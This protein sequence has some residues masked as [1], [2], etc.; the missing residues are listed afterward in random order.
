LG[1]ALVSRLVELHGGSIAVQSEVGRGSRFTISLPWTGIYQ[2]PRGFGPALASLTPLQAALHQAVQSSSVDPTNAPA[3]RSAP[4]EKMAKTS[5]LLAEDNEANIQTIAD[6]LTFKGYH[7]IVARNGVEAIDRA[8]E[9]GPALI[10]MDIQMPVM[11]GLEAIRSLRADPQLA[12]T[13]IIALTALAMSGDR[14]RCLAAGANDYMAK[15]VSLK[16]L[17]RLIESYLNQS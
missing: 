8:R 11:D 17:L 9:L 4:V 6:F 7:V 3:E 1:L 10:L 12:D 2:T 14:E 16:N 13:P 5:I 15:P